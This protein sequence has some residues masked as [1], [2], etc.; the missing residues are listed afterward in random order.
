MGREGVGALVALGLTALVI[1]LDS[2]ALL[3]L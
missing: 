2:N 1:R 3:P